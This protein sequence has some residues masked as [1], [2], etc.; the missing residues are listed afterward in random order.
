MIFYFSGTGNSL[1][2]AEVLQSDEQIVDMAE[3]LRRR[4]CGFHIRAGEAV[5]LVC[6]VYYSGVP[7]L[8]LE[9]IRHLHL[10]DDYTYTYLVL[11]HGG[12]PGA[13]GAM[14]EHELKKKGYHL[15]AIYDVKMPANYVMV[16]QPA[17]QEEEDQRILDAEP[18]IRDIRE[19][20][21]ERRFDL[22]DYSPVSRALTWSMYPLCDRY[23]PTK[24][25]YTD[26]SC[27]GCG[28][29]AKRCPV[30]AITMVDG[31]P[32]WQKNHCIRCMSCL[33]CNAIQY[34]NIIKDKRRYRYHEVKE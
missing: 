34:G 3:A 19:A 25:F 8:V 5:G 24:K 29:C 31:R 21:L 26:D 1:H 4:R 33:R 16:G 11:T 9:F 17:A 28:V 22:P 20:V 32:V 10:K 13:A 23:M 2:V 12:G 7:K 14:V 18:V 6:P 30:D 15:D 27:I